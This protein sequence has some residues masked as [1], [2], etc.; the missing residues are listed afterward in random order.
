[1]VR[2]LA[3]L[4]SAN[5]YKQDT[6]LADMGANQDSAE[7]RRGGVLNIRSVGWNWP[8]QG[9]Y[10]AHESLP[11]MLND[12]GCALCPCMLSQG[13]CVTDGES[14][15]VGSREILLGNTGRVQVF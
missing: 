6:P 8:V 10:P 2:S 15:R 4:N 11:L 1:M 9:S 13:Q 12:R 14:E 3:C 5:T 7:N